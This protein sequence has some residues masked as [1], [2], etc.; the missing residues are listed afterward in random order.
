VD[1]T[2][3]KCNRKFSHATFI[4]WGFEITFD[5]TG[6]RAERQFCIASI[7]TATH[8]FLKT[9][10]RYLRKYASGCNITL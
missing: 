9:A 2:V 1:E 4:P 3:N 10:V 6:D 5:G 8:G 7:F